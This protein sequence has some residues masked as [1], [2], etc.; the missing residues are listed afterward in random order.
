MCSC[1]I[2]YTFYLIINLLVLSSSS[3]FTYRIRSMGEDSVFTLST[4][5]ARGC[6][7]CGGSV[8]R[9]CGQGEGYVEGGGCVTRRVQPTGCG[10]PP[11]TEDHSSQ[12][13][14][15]PP[16]HAQGNTRI[17]SMRR[18]CVSYW[19]V[20]LFFSFNIIFT[21]VINYKRFYGIVEMNM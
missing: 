14:A 2:I 19:N 7:Q 16:G 3:I 11:K 4:G 17:Q 20:F 9:G 21:D 6:D 18:R 13:R 15:P 1:F 8:G 10:R 12:D 5:V